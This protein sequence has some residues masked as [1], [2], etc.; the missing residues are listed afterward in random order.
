MIRILNKNIIFAV[1]P[2]II[3]LLATVTYAFNV[4]VKAY[5]DSGELF[6]NQPATFVIEV[7]GASGNVTKPSLPDFEG[8][9]VYSGSTGQSQNWTVINGKMSASIS[10]TYGII[11]LKEGNTKIP[12]ITVNIDGKD[13]KTESFTVEVKK[14]RTV[15]PP[16]AG[17]NLPDPSGSE[18]DPELFLL[19]SP[20]KREV[21]QNEGITLEYKVYIGQNVEVSEYSQ[22]NIPYSQG[23]WAED[24]SMPRQPRAVPE[25]YNNKRYNAAVLKKVELFPTNSGE[26]DIDPMEMQ[27]AVRSNNSTRNR[28]VFDSFF[29]R[30]TENVKVRSND[31]KITVKPLP[32]EGRP[33]NFSGAV[34]KYSMSASVDK[35]NIKENESITMKI[36]ISGEGNI[37]L[38]NEP[39]LDLPDYFEVYDPKVGEKIDKLG[40]TVSGEKTFE[41]VLIPRRRG[42]YS[43][44]PV[45]FAFFDPE[46]RAYKVI[47]TRPLSINVSPDESVI[48][49]APRNLNRDEIRVLGQDVRFLKENVTKWGKIGSRDFMSFS[50]L[51]LLFTP[52]LL[53]LGAFVYSRRL[54]KLNKDIGYKRSIRANTIA[55]KRLKKAHAMLTKNDPEAFF[56]EVAKAL[57]EYIA[58][59]LNVAAAGIVTDEIERI[60]KNMQIDDDLLRSY[61]D[62]LRTCDFHRFSSMKT[63]PEEM[64]TLYDD[65][66]NAIFNMEERL[67]KSA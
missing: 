28:S 55:V 17:G 40:S 51:S 6:V 61:I 7:S 10:Y 4:T 38:I 47:E 11:P 50:F 41:Y 2:V 15:T 18:N 58:D 54:Q 34:G 56:P 31:L 67:K 52:V 48:S 12:Q 49:N 3:L 27:F 66:K 62:C 37:K 65:S 8:W 22:L 42:N 19:V 20:D 59:K 25:M 24:Y 16:P 43:L 1:V 30:A 33:S 46:L 29:N 39:V 36:T 5:F 44:D 21:Y 14:E 32:V 64:S 26:F 13:Y 60:L 35:M 57:Q 53:V 9:F 45:S 63:S 23:F